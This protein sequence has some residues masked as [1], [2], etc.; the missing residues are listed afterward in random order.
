DGHFTPAAPNGVRAPGITYLWSDEGRLYPAIVPGLFN[1]EVVGR[2]NRAWRRASWPVRRPWPGSAKD[3]A[4]GL[5]HRS[6]RGGRYASHAF[7]D[8]LKGCG[9][10]RRTSHKGNCRDNAPTGSR[11][12]SFKNG[13]V[14]GIRYATRAEMKAARFEYISVYR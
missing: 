6:G 8:N 13:R 3:P 11:S 1:R 4:P 9:M 5:M 12:N 2:P 14:H 7:Q 10:T